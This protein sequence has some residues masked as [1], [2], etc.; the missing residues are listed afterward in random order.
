MGSVEMLFLSSEAACAF[1]SPRSFLIDVVE[2][3]E[4]C[5]FDARDLLSSWHRD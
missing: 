3:H 5:T 4:I 2:V 1:V